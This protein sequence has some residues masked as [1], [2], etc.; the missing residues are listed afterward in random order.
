MLQTKKKYILKY[1]LPSSQN[2]FN[3]DIFTEDSI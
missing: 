3:E 2:N 1:K